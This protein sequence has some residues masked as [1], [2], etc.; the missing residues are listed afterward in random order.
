[1]TD[2]NGSNEQ[3]TRVTRTKE[4]RL[5]GQNKTKYGCV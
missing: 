5:K 1:M 2:N 4:E 3:L